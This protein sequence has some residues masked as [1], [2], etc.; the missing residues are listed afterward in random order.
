MNINISYLLDWSGWRECFV[1]VL[2][3]YVGSEGDPLPV[4]GSR[5]FLAQALHRAG[6][7][8]R[9]LH[10]LPGVYDVPRRVFKKKNCEIDW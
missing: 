10:P 2:R 6:D 3:G 4:V 1:E 9:R 7:I 8:D 5:L